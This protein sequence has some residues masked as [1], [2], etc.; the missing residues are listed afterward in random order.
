MRWMLATTLIV[1]AG[2]SPAARFHI[3]VVDGD[4]NPVTGFRYLVQ[5]DTTYTVD[6]NN[7][8]PIGQQLALNFHKSYHPPARVQWGPK[9]GS[10]LGGNEDT[11]STPVTQVRPGRYFVSVLPYNGHALGGAPVT[12]LP[13]TR[14][15]TDSL[16]DVT[17]VVEK[18]PIP[19][20]QISVFLFHDCYPLNGAPDLPEEEPGSGACA[21]A[22]VDFSQFRIV[23]EEPAGKYGANGGPMLLDA[24]GNL[25][26]TVYGNQDT[27]TPVTGPGGCPARADGSCADGTLIPNPDGTLV[28]NNVAPGKY[29][30]IVTT[31]PGWVQT[32][33]LEGSPVID[34]WVKA[35][36]PVFMV[37]F[38]LPGPHV[39]VGFTQERNTLS[40][41]VSA[42]TV[43]GRITDMHMSRPTDTRLYSGRPFPQCWIAINEGGLKP[44]ANRY[45]APCDPDSSFSIPNVPPGSYQLKVFDKPLDAVIAS[46]NFTV[47]PAGTCNGGQSCAFDDV[48]VFTWF[49]R[50]LTWIFS[51]TNQNG[52][53]DSGESSLGAESGPVNIR[54]RDGTVYQSFPSDFEGSAPFDEVFPWFNWMVAEVGFTNK[55]ATGV[56]VV[57]D[58]G[59]AVDSAAGEVFPGYGT[60]TPQLQAQINPNTGDKLART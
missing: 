48:P 56:T 30:V 51:D 55:K 33:T 17:V 10:A 16:D 7:P 20:A 13:N 3:N 28:I 52:F 4:G 38:G 50:L 24:F 21:P 6:P 39:F 37:E 41:G 12:V 47:D 9:A 27:N 42:A 1:S 8:P 5:E 54:W 36:E 11:D 2:V 22:D 19:A 44:G 35:G 57:V 49:N 15:P 18:H 46:M 26:G 43:S 45:A 23:L 58:G 32:S 40:D 34:A 25:L 60:L 14:D 59:G 31:A 29:G 53:W